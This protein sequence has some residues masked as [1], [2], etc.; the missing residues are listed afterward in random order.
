M[1]RVG[2]EIFP[3][4]SFNSYCKIKTW[5]PFLYWEH[6]NQKITDSILVVIL[7]KNEKYI[8]YFDQSEF[9]TQSNTPASSLVDCGYYFQEWSSFSSAGSSPPNAKFVFLNQKEP[10]ENATIAGF[11]KGTFDQESKTRVR[12]LES[13]G[14]SF[15]NTVDLPKT[16]DIL[17]IS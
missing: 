14:I 12:G 8:A 7:N 15:I 6:E 2:K 16:V 1:M 9:I 5:A 13:E 3:I 4:N 17:I 10:E 11:T